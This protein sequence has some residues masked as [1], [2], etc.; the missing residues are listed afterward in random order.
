MSEPRHTGAR[1]A[2]NAPQGLRVPP[3]PRPALRPRPAD[4]YVSA[5]LIDEFHLA[6]GVLLAGPL[7]PPRRGATGPRLA[8]VERIEGRDPKEYPPPRVGRTHRRRP[9]QVDPPRNRPRAA[10]DAGDGHVHAHRHGPARADRRPAAD[11]QD[12][13]APAHRAGGAQELP[14]HA[15]H[16][17][18]RGRAAGGS[19]RDPPDAHRHRQ[20]RRAASVDPRRAR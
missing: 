6:E 10:H 1:R 2:G 3:Q 18:A 19:D 9:D 17:A 20:H 16:G 4:A 11:R 5:Q 8:A 14:G 7:E 12:R 15:P 13:P